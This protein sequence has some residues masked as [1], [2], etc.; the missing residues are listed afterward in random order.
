MTSLRRVRRWARGYA[1]GQVDAYLTAV[2][3]ALASPE[4]GLGALEVR[5]AGFDLVRGGYDIA[6]VD[7]TLDALELRAVVAEVAAVP[8]DQLQRGLRDEAAAV[9]ALLEGEDGERFAREPGLVNGYDPRDVDALVRRLLAR[10]PDLAAQAALD[11]APP[12][13]DDVRFTA[14]RRRRGG[15][16]EDTV[17]EVMDRVIDVLL[18]AQV[19]AAGGGA[20]D[21]DQDRDQHH[22]QHHEQAPPVDAVPTAPEEPAHGSA[23]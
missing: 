15:Y 2:E 16:V 6:T 18:R 7:R 5:R 11:A 21:H 14:F 22:D 20:P 10:W 8:R 19:L 23:V 3:E 1:V 9:R 17:D 4:P 12:D 13:P